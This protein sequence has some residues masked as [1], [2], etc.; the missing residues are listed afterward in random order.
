MDH[1]P[2]VTGFPDD[3]CRD[4]CMLMEPHEE[5]MQW[6]G[7]CDNDGYVGNERCKACEG[8]RMVKCSRVSEISLVTGH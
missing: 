8:T 6:C 4:G 5:C 3:Y 1:R 7:V 2:F